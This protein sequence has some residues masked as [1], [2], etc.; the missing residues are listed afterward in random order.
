MF[1]KLKSCRNLRMFRFTLISILILQ[2]S[3]TST[4]FAKNHILFV[5]DG[6]G[7]SHI[8]GARLFK[9]GPKARLNLESM[10]YTGIVRTSSY[11][12]FTTDS[13]AAATALASGV[14]TYNTAIGV[15]DPKK[16]TDKESSNLIT[17]VDQA[18]KA[19]KAV[20]L[21]TTARVTHATPAAFYAH[22][23]HRDMEDS[24]AEQ[25]LAS[26]IDL[27]F[28]G[29]QRFF[30]GTKAGGS[31][32][33]QRDLLQEFALK[34]YLVIKTD[35]EFRSLQMNSKQKILALLGNDH[36]PFE[37][38]RTPDQVSL[39]ELVDVAIQHL[40]KNP[41]GYFLMVEAA[42]VDHASHKNFARHSFGDMLALDQALE[43]PLLEDDKQ[44]LV[45]VTSDHET[46]GLALNGYA[47][48]EVASG[49]KILGNHKRYPQLPLTDHGIVS[50]SSGP[51]HQAKV[52]IRE[53]NFQHISAY[54]IPNAYH[55]AVDVPIMS[56]GPG[57]E[58]FVGFMD[59]SDI[60]HKVIE[61]MNLEPINTNE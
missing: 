7:Q 6:M 29:G 31:R 13:A 18:K 17:I 49:E 20:G 59:N 47:P 40:S 60:V 12:D 1:L 36:L 19:G 16:A 46:G 55:T 3:C 23:A 9:G 39:K 61:I 30:L 57:A 37:L 54:K 51:G 21:I 48:Y 56:K 53:K 25:L 4:Q 26:D 2:T 45:I 5:V 43:K 8:T 41:K 50:W 34:N 27:I 28:G 32:E 44:T 14:R 42:R 22:V 11:D 33:D 15:S 24:I 58:K 52:N 38:D 35:Q 10:P